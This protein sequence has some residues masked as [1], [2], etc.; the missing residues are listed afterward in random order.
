M[1]G[2]DTFFAETLSDSPGVTISHPTGNPA[3]K[4]QVAWNAADLMAMVFPEPNW[5]VPGIIA[6]G[7]SLLCGPPKVGKSWASLDLALQVASGGQ[8]FGSI[9]VEQGDV[10]Y[11]ALEDTPQRLQSRMGMLLEGRP[12]PEALTLVTEC[13]TMDRG[14]SEAIDNWLTNH[15]TPGWS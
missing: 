6:E 12:A 2:Q 15:R 8:A 11:L 14:G 5:A 4:R 1:K 7:V 9:P 13:P 3:P 10:L